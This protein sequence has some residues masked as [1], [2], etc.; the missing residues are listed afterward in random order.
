[1]AR[2]VPRPVPYSLHRIP[3]PLPACFLLCPARLTAKARS[4]H[5]GPVALSA[6]AAIQ[7]LQARLYVAE[8][9]THAYHGLK[10]A[11]A[12]DEQKY[13]HTKAEHDT[14][15]KDL[16]KQASACDAVAFEA[17]SMCVCVCVYSYVRACACAHARAV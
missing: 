13:A 8:Q 16:A 12:T 17:T 11:L 4:S 6:T 3:P 10:A 2:L 9:Q 15:R 14:E 5:T 1:M 7:N